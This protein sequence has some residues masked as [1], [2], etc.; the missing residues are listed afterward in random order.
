METSHC[1]FPRHQVAPV[2]VKVSR[3]I[4]A[5]NP[6]STIELATTRHASSPDVI[7]GSQARDKPAAIDIAAKTTI[8][9]S[10]ICEKFGVIL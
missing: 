6:I 2:R 10:E 3:N 5:A 4:P 9:T 1:H 8:I 7:L